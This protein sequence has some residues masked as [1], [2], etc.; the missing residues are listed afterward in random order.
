SRDWSSDV[1]SS[2]LPEVRGE[3]AV[4]LVGRHAHAVILDADYRPAVRDRQCDVD[5]H[6][7]W[8]VLERV[9][10]QVVE[11]LRDA[12]WVRARTR[13][14]VRTVE[15]KARRL[16]VLVSHDRRRDGVAQVLRCELED[17]WIGRAMSVLSPSPWCAAP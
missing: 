10:K 3:Q 13:C 6:V 7:G 5:R 12:A 4:A 2:D 14:Y 15:P 16:R 17:G 8:A 1:C 11:D 9:V